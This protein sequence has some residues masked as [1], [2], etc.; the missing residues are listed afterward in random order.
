MFT[1]RDFFGAGGFAVLRISLGLSSPLS[2][3]AIAIESLKRTCKFEQSSIFD[4]LRTQK[5]KLHF[6]FESK[7]SWSY[8]LLA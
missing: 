6:N 2:Q 7:C 4:L 3:G 1:R 8:C 5:V